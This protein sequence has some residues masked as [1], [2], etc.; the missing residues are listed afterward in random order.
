MSVPSPN[1]TNGQTG[2]SVLLLPTMIGRVA[3]FHRDKCS[4]TS[5]RYSVMRDQ[6]SF[7]HGTIVAGFD[8][9]GD[10]PDRL[11]CGRWTSQ[12][13]LVVS[14]DRAGRMICSRAFHQM[15]GGGP[16]AV[17]VE[18]R[19]NDAAAEHPRKRFLISLG[20]KFSDDFV[21]L[22]KAANLQ[23][24]FVCRPAPK[25]R[26]IWRESFLDAFHHLSFKFQVSGFRFQVSSP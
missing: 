24:P 22:R 26:V 13:N 2:K 23:S 5:C 7:N 19:T 9:A 8:H 11:V 17:T 4:A 10:E 15:V 25:A 21:A 14:S 3:G 20:L 18:Q 1:R 12:S 6:L 16:V